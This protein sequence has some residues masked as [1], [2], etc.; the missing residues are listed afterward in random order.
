MEKDTNNM[1]PLAIIRS[2]LPNLVRKI[3]KL[4][5]YEW[6]GIK[7]D[8]DNHIEYT[9]YDVGTLTKPWLSE[10]D[11][12]YI[13]QTFCENF[14]LGEYYLFEREDKKLV[15]SIYEK[16][17]PEEYKILYDGRKYSV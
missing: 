1:T 17:N 5:D 15:V 6:V 12:G 11:L 2:E 14:K 9:G 3:N 8:E 13:E 10:W 7:Y 4:K 16:D